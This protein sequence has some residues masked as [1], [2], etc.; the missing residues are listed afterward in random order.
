MAQG[1]VDFSGDRV[2]DFSG[3][4][5]GSD[6]PGEEALRFYTDFS[7]RT[8]ETYSW[9][10]RQP[11]AAEAVAAGRV[12]MAFLN[13]SSVARLRHEQPRLPLL[14]AAVPQLDDSGTPV[15]MADYWLYGVAKASHD[16]QRSWGVLQEMAT[17]EAA[18][19]KFAETSKRGPTLRAVATTLQQSDDPEVVALANQSL[20]ARTWYH[21]YSL[22][23]AQRAFSTVL[24]S[25]SAGTTNA[26]DAIGELG[27]LVRLTY[28]PN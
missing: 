2:P 7:Q 18:L 24:D 25:L 28:Q 21:G 5:R 4:V 10:S 6:G 1:G 16:G 9:D 13:P 12:A 19:A 26:E 22:A 8:K 14:M 11:N 15:A 23:A 20:V 3:G 17:N 27:R